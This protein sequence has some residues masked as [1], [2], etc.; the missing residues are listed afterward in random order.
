M[1]F[2][3]SSY[4]EA[5]RL[6]PEVVAAFLGGMHSPQAP[7][8]PWLVMIDDWNPPS[9]NTLLR[10]HWSKRARVKKAATN[11]VAQAVREAGVPVATG[12]R[13]VTITVVGTNRSHL[14]DP[15]NTIKVLLDSLTRSGAI[16]DDC[17]EWCECLMPVV[18]KGPEKMTR[19]VIEDMK[20]VIS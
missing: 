1:G 18:E 17:S 7:G 20:E 15:D 6:G 9:L 14:C 13:R 12:K 19:I 3:V 11:R 16:V 8:G 5:L 4:A 2:R 10:G